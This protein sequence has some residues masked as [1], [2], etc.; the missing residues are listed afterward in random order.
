[1]IM[2]GYHTTTLS[3]MINTVGKD[4]PIMRDDG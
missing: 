2:G 3:V 1:M 4:L